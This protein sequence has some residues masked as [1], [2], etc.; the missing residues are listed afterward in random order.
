VICSQP[1][2]SFVTG[3]PS[4]P[5]NLTAE[6]IGRDTVTLKWDKPVNTGGV[7]LTGYIIEQVDGKSSRWRVSAY[8]DTRTTWWTI[9]NLIQGFE[10]NFRVRA[11]NPD[12]AGAACV[13]ASP[14]IP[15]PTISKCHTL[16]RESVLY[17]KAST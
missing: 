2:R 5:S 16:S 17:V 3:L 9:S 14:V 15:K 7:P 6:V 13:L 1:P 12:G 4:A 11:E 8:T 10:Y